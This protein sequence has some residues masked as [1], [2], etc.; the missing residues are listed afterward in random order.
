MLKLIS[1]D[2]QRR[3]GQFRSYV[4][5]GKYLR[6]SGKAGV[7]YVLPDNAVSIAS[8]RTITVTKDKYGKEVEMDGSVY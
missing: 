4:D 7:Y 5:I 2:E 6:R 8:M 1:L 3:I